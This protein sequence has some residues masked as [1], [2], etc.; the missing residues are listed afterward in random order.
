MTDKILAGIIE[1]DETHIG[2]KEQNKHAKKKK[3]GDAD[4]KEKYTFRA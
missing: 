1:S 2:G 3:K 4:Q